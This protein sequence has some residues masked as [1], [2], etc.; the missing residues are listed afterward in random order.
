MWNLNVFEGLNESIRQLV[1]IEPVWNLNTYYLSCC[2]TCHTCEYRTSV[3]FKQ[4][5][6]DQTSRQLLS[7]YRTSV[8]FKHV[9]K[10]LYHT[11]FLV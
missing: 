4:S 9:S 3:E 8:E 7:E 6:T 10:Y 2:Y 11:V 5:I 1:S